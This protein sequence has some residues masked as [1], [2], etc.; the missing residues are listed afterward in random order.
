VGI[1]NLINTFN[2]QCII[3]GGRVSK[4]SDLFLPSCMETVR[5]RAWYASTKDVKVSRLERGEV[6]GAAALVL[7]QIFSTGQIVRRAGGSGQGRKSPAAA[8]RRTPASS[9]APAASARAP[10]AAPRRSALRTSGGRT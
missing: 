7:Q 1:S 10:K 8:R 3:L 6:L 9:A 4:A 2:P 5:Q